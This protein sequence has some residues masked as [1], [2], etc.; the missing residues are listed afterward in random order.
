MHSEREENTSLHVVY[1]TWDLCSSLPGFH[2]L[3]YGFRNSTISIFVFFLQIIVR[4][5]FQNCR[6]VHMVALL[7]TVPCLFPTR[8]I[9]LQL[10][11]MGS[12]PLWF[13]MLNSPSPFFVSLLPNHLHFPKYNVVLS[14]MPSCKLTSFTRWPGKPYSVLEKLSAITLHRSWLFIS[15]SPLFYVNCFYQGL[16]FMSVSTESSTGPDTE[17]DLKCVFEWIIKM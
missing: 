2:Q 9:K 17:W 10:L 16:H 13:H 8:T 5:G 3:P 6:S 7:K 1:D 11:G 15:L 12:S 14:S 4:L